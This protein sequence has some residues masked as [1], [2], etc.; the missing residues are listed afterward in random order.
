MKRSVILSLVVVV[1]SIAYSQYNPYYTFAVGARAGSTGSTCG[2]TLKYFFSN[3]T[4]GEAIIGY[5]HGALAGTLLVEQH[6]QPTRLKELQGYWGGGVHYV[7][8]SGYRNY[9]LIDNR[10]RSYQD[11]GKGYGLDLIA[12]IEYKFIDIPLAISADVKPALEFN[13]YGG[14]IVGIDKSIGIKLAL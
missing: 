13:S 11:G 14:F 3:K 1:Q 5:N 2:G 12:G 7:H 9:I 4:A 8:S 6:F 10:V